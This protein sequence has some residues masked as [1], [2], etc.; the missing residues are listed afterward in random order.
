[1]KRVYVILSVVLLSLLAVM[2]LNAKSEISKNST[3]QKGEEV[4]IN[5]PVNAAG[6]MDIQK[7]SGKYKY[8]KDNPDEAQQAWKVIG[9]CPTTHSNF[10]TISTFYFS[11]NEAGDCENESQHIYVDSSAVKGRK[12]NRFKQ[13]FSYFK[14]AYSSCHHHLPSYGMF[15]AWIKDGNLKYMYMI[16]KANEGGLMVKTNG[17]DNFKQTM[18]ET[19]KVKS[20]VNVQAQLSVNSDIY[21][22][23]KSFEFT[24]KKKA[25]HGKVK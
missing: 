19:N 13:K 9:E 21:T 17:Y 1:M 10:D 14:T 3:A 15:K 24:A 4:V 7:G 20:S 2:Y 18:S 6:A 8:K 5:I 16:S 22:T 23:Q 11:M 25:L 12:R